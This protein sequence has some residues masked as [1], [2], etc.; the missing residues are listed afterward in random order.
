MKT[1]LQAAVLAHW[2][3]SPGARY[4]ILHATKA[5]DHG[6]VLFTKHFEEAHN[7]AVTSL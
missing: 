6:V 1:F 4:R 3:H 2:Y 5:L 7:F